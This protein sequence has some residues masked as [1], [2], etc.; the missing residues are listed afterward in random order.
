MQQ[1]DRWRGGVARFAVK[2]TAATDR[3]KMIC[4]SEMSLRHGGDFL[5]LSN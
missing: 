4:C 5:W 2:D 3:G 1:D